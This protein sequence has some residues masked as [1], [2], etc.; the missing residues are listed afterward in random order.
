MYETYRGKVEF[1]L[2]YIREA[3]PTDGW[4]IK[5]NL[6]DDILFLQPTTHGQRV[7]LAKEMCET[8]HLK[9][10]TL[11]DHIDNRVGQAYNALPDRL[12]LIGGDGKVAYKGAHG[13]RGFV[14]SEL[15][16]AIRRELAKDG[17]SDR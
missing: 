8:L 1:F 11:I 13:P 17:Q 12:V 15:E 5:A 7:D 14:P 16:R 10:P 4:Q 9:M 2:V 3:H 6:R